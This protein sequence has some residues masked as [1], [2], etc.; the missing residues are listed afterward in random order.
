M[1][2]ELIMRRPK[3]RGTAIRALAAALA[4][5]MTVLTIGATPALA[6]AG[7]ARVAAPAAV[8]GHATDVKPVAAPA[9]DPALTAAG[10]ATAARIATG[11]HYPSAGTA[12]VGVPAAGMIS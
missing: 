6:A 1:D 9:P 12:T 7:H 11:I 2:I 4:T 10:R 5:T 3:L 8:L